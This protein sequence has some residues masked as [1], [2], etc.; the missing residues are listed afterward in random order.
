VEVELDEAGTPTGFRHVATL[1]MPSKKYKDHH[2]DPV[3]EQ[4]DELY[5]FTSDGCFRAPP[6]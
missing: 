2:A 3:M 6:V 1:K 5:L 4:G